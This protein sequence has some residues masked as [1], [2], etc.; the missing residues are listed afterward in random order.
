MTDP[1]KMYLIRN[2]T[3]LLKAHFAWSRYKCFIRTLQ[4]LKY[5]QELVYRETL[6]LQVSANFVPL[7]L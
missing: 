2:Q 6:I 3:R 4:G 7:K 1:G 5:S